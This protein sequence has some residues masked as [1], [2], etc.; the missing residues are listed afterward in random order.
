MKKEK[1]MKQELIKLFDKPKQKV[2][3]IFN[4]KSLLRYI[5]YA[6][7]DYTTSFD[8]MRMKNVTMGIF[9]VISTGR[10]S[11][12]DENKIYN[13]TI[14]KLIDF[15]IHLYQS[16]DTQHEVSKSIEAYL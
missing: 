5:D 11:A 8:G 15:I 6:A 16:C 1:E 14:N 12:N 9:Y 13:M 2:K 7:N 10:I 4:L 3:D